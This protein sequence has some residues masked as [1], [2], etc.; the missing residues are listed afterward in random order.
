MKRFMGVI[1]VALLVL[2]GIYFLT[3]LIPDQLSV[4]K[5]GVVLPSTGKGANYGEKTRAGLDIAIEEYEKQRAIRRI[6]L[7]YEDSQGDPKTAVT[8]VKKLINVDK[9]VAII[10]PIYSDNVLAVS[11]IV[12]KEKVTMLVTAAASDKIR[13]AG[14][15]VFRNRVSA[16]EISTYLARYCYETLGIESVSVLYENS[17]NAIDYK[18]T[19]IKEFKKKGGSIQ[20]EE[21]F[22]KGGKDFR[23]QIAKTK[24]VQPDTVFITGHATEIGLFLRQAHELGLDAK[25]VSTP[26][27]ESDDMLDIAG[28]AAEGL[29][30]ASEALDLTSDD[31]LIQEFRRKYKER[32]D[33]QEPDFFSANA[34]DAFRMIIRAG[35][36]HGFTSD[37]IKRGL[38]ELKDFYGVSGRITFDKDGEVIKPLSIKA[39]KDGRFMVLEPPF[40]Q[41]SNILGQK[42]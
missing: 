11:P 6:S 31:S 34:Y 20:I 37:G 10:G 32:M 15:F 4:V 28:S 14:D 42:E 39:V 25:F 36:R 41:K 29:L 26:G 9:V 38:N 24:D 3:Q 35:E 19:F 17:A 18:N 7:I 8:A 16:S 5:I 40:V 2:V 30:L 12:E 22:E 33:K 23:T 1:V 21:S 27:A 13:E